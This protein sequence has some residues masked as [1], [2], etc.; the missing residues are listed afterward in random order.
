MIVPGHFLSSDQQTINRP[1]VVGSG[2]VGLACARTIAKM[3]LPV[4]VIEAG[5]EIADAISSDLDVEMTASPLPGARIGRTRQIGGGVNLWGGQLAG[6]QGDELSSGGVDPSG[7]P[8]DLADIISRYTAATETFGQRINIQNVQIPESTFANGTLRQ[9]G[10]D[11]VATA[12]LDA[13]KL[14]RKVWKDISQSRLLT[15]A[16]GLCVNRIRID[17]NGR[18]VGVETISVN[19]SSNTFYG[20]SV[21]LAC[22]TIETIRLL[23]L[24]TDSNCSSPWGALPWLGCGFNDHLDAEVATVRPRDARMLT[25]VFDPFFFQGIKYS[26]KTS[27][28]FKVDNGPKLHTVGMLSMPGNIRNSLSEVRLLLKGLTPQEIGMRGPSLA[29]AGASACAQLLPIA[30]RFLRHKRLATVF[31]GLGTFRVSI[32]QPLRQRSAITLSSTTD[33]FGI[34]RASLHWIKG[35]EE[36]QLFLQKARLLKAWAESSGAA[37]VVINQNLLRDPMGFVASADDGLHHAGGARI[38]GDKSL[39]VVDNDLA[40]FGTTGLYC[41]GAAVFPRMGFANP[42]LTAAALAVRL[43]EHIANKEM[44][45]YN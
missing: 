22:G 43:A 6:L 14:P 13:P 45:T 29:R 9:S 37:E 33:R 2:P 16:Y 18:V 20:N 42:T 26:P 15:I 10:L 19:G 1:I 3:G 27:A 39:G 38:A 30:W 44:N 36:G 17:D 11:I 7:W 28:A 21:I 8:L 25:N 32:E 31:R 40:V 23:L 41:C 24:P 5:A 12:W 4:L 35:S 34:P